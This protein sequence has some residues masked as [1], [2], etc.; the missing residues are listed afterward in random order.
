MS[1]V[2]VFQWNVWYERHQKLSYG[3]NLFF[4]FK[5]LINWR[6]MLGLQPLSFDFDFSFG[7][8]ALKPA[9]VLFLFFVCSYIQH[10]ISCYIYRTS[11]I[12]K[13]T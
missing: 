3:S 9:I 13:S 12:K 11:L 10:K 6:S 8:P 5:L 2:M 7:A 1:D 4:Y